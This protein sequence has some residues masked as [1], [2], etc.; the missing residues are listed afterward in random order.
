MGVKEVAKNSAA[1]HAES[2][3][4]AV[5]TVV[6]RSSRPENKNW[7]FSF[8]NFQ[9]IDKFGLD[10][11][12][13]AN[14]WLVS[15]LERLKQLSQESIENILGD[16]IMADSYRYHAINWT[17]KNIPIERKALDWISEPYKSNPEEYPIDQIMLSKGT[18]R[19]VGFFDENWV[20][21]L[22]L[23]DPLH[24]LQP[25]KDFNYTV[26]PSSP[27]NC[28]LTQLQMAVREGLQH[29]SGHACVASARIQ[30][31]LDEKTYSERYGIVLLKVE[32]AQTLKDAQDLIAEKGADSYTEIF[33]TGLCFMIENPKSSS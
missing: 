20:F 27:L 6:K 23:L 14:D 1:K 18:G 2:E 11:G 30:D 17:A 12:G 26:N 16:H 19:I 7:E 25:S 21:H 4:A 24:N 15:L 5:A 3:S 28:Q 8:K 33:E 13:I 10:G 32:D 29:C 9:Q 31:A 22:V